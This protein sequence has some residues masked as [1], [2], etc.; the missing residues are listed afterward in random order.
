MFDFFLSKSRDFLSCEVVMLFIEPWH[1]NTNVYIK[2]HAIRTD[3]TP[4]GAEAVYLWST[5]NN[6]VIC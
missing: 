2:M 1:Y 6:D 3:F 5:F 4:T